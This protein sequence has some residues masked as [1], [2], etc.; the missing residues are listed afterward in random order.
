MIHDAAPV[1]VAAR[2]V[3]GEHAMSVERL[4]YS[5]TG[6]L[7]VTSWHRSQDMMCSLYYASACTIDHL[8]ISPEAPKCS[9]ISSRDLTKKWFTMIQLG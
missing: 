4:T 3:R 1:N 8:L 2:L 7:P 6:E 5:P 9:G